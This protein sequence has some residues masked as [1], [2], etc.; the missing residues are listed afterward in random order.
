MRVNFKAIP[1]Q[2]PHPALPGQQFQWWPILNV[3]LFYKH[4]RTPA[5][6]AV[7]DSGSQTCLFHANFG[8]LLGIDIES[9]VEGPL[10]GVI[11]GAMGKVYYHKI[12]ALIAG[13]SYEIAAGFSH[14][15]S[16]AGLLGQVGFFDHFITTFDYN[17]YPPCF[18]VTRIRVN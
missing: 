18:E 15:L 13:E 6:E 9:G 14:Q 12:R 2:T 11:G 3:V 10:G 16:C 17:P 8:R 1:L 4:K 7:V 5:I